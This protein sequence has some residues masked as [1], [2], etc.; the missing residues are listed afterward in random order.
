MMWT[1]NSRLWQEQTVKIKLYMFTLKLFW[2]FRTSELDSKHCSGWRVRIWL[3]Q[4]PLRCSIT[5]KSGLNAIVQLLQMESDTQADEKRHSISVYDEEEWWIQQSITMMYESL[6]HRLILKGGIIHLVSREKW[7]P[8]C[9]RTGCVRICKLLW[10]QKEEQLLTTTYVSCTDH[11]RPGTFSSILVHIQLRF[12]NAMDQG[13]N[14]FLLTITSLS[15]LHWLNWKEHHWLRTSKDLLFRPISFCCG[16]LW[17]FL[18]EQTYAMEMQS[19]TDNLVFNSPS[20]FL[21]WPWFVP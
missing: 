1:R 13:V 7:G 10:P 9:S 18:V 11:V 17:T 16:T 3:R 14:V 5:E 19:V 4:F 12:F 15:L 20:Q 21:Y 6:R 2:I 8:A